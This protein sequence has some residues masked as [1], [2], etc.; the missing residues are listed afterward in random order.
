MNFALMKTKFVWQNC[1]LFTDEA[2]TL[3]KEVNNFFRLFFLCQGIATQAVRLYF[4]SKVPEHQLKS[5]LKLHKS[6]LTSQGSRYKCT[7]EQEMILFPGES[8]L[9]AMSIIIM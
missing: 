8:F 4:D 7:K 1:L 2:D 5:F 9:I 3:S 6:D